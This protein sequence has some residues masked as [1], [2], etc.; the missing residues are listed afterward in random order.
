M[1][2][3]ILYFICSIDCLSCCDFLI[4]IHEST[5]QKGKSNNAIN[6]KKHTNHKYLS[7]VMF[8]YFK[9][10]PIRTS[11]SSVILR[12]PYLRTMS[13]PTL[14][15]SRFAGDGLFVLKRRRLGR[16]RCDFED[17]VISVSTRGP[18]FRT[19]TTPPTSMVVSLGVVLG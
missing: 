6:P 11:L 14:T 3:F 15:P 19:K 5:S 4:S 1:T 9:T 16:G 7:W 12:V 8:V 10:C 13:T 17:Q 18:L 2:L